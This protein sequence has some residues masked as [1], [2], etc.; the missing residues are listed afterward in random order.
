MVEL[1][2]T[3]GGSPFI[4]DIDLL[5]EAEDNDVTITPNPHDFGLVPTGTTA[6]QLF[7]ITNT[8][9]TAV[10]SAISDPLAAVSLPFRYTGGAYPGAS[11]NC[12]A[13]PFTL[14]ASAFCTIDVEFAPTATGEFSDMLSLTYSLGG[15]AGKT[16]AAEVEGHGCPP[17]GGCNLPATIESMTPASIPTSTVTTVTINGH[18][19]S[20]PPAVAVLGVGAPTVVGS[21]VWVDFDEITVTF[22]ATATAG[23]FDVDVTND[24]GTNTNVAA[25]EV[26][27]FACNPAA[28]IA[29]AGNVTI[30]GGNGATKT[31]AAGAWDSGY[32]DNV[33]SIQNPAEYIEFEITARSVVAGVSYNPTASTN[34]T[35]ADFAFYMFSDT[36]PDVSRYQAGTLQGSSAWTPGRKFRIF[37]N[38]SSRAEWQIET[39]VGTGV[40][41]VEQTSATAITGPLFPFGAFGRSGTVANYLVCK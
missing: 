21:P 30:V 27:A 3:L 39:G 5:G 20:N 4:T 15:V 35:N 28:L 11:G 36:G 29:N 10:A 23:L 1:N 31:T 24:C 22:S 6:S 33:N 37:I 32:F 38:A 19:F 40:F 9:T 16:S 34:W 7:T 25:L 17:S 14:A 26:K 2:Y 41:N 12:P 8:N 18:N 13:V